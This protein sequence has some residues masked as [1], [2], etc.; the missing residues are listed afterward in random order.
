M[1]KTKIT[2]IKRNNSKN[3]FDNGQIIS[4]A[5]NGILSSIYFW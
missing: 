1:S 2:K 5:H 3:K 4:Q